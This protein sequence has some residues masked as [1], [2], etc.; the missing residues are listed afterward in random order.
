M[1]ASLFIITPAALLSFGMQPK[2]TVFI[3]T[4]GICLFVINAEAW[5]DTGNCTMGRDEL[6]LISHNHLRAFDDKGKVLGE[7]VRGSC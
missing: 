5:Q 3:H 1:A 2:E 4:D 7:C 6:L